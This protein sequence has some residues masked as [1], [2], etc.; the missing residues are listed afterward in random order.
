M[1]SY[2]YNQSVLFCREICFEA[3]L[4]GVLDEKLLRGSEVYLLFQLFPESDE[5]LSSLVKL[6]CGLNDVSGISNESLDTFF[7][8]RR[9]LRLLKERFWFVDEV[10]P[11]LSSLSSKSSVYVTSSS[12]ELAISCSNDSCKSR[13]RFSEL[14]NSFFFRDNSSSISCS[15]FSCYA[16]TNDII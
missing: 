5:I 7:D 3:N 14:I 13:I 9:L 1:G 2:F 15:R 16:N 6:R 12:E 4:D 8:K 10:R 11:K